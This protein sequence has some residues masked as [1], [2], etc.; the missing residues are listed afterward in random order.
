MPCISAM[1]LG[2]PTTTQAINYL[3]QWLAKTGRSE[4]SV[5]YYHNVCSKKSVLEKQ[6]LYLIQNRPVVS[7]SLF[8]TSGPF[9]I[10]TNP[11]FLICKS[12]SW[13]TLKSHLAAKLDPL[14][15]YSCQVFHCQILMF[16]YRVYSQTPLGYFIRYSR[17]TLLFLIYLLKYNSHVVKFTIFKFT[18]L[19]I[20]TNDVY[21][22]MATTSRYRTCPGP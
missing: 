7:Y 11:Q 13:K 9:W 21:S 12:K 19:W 2:T 22:C 5:F 14:N 8:Y 1:G 17:C 18:V 4:T 15:I 16:D 10:V 6:N 3:C 20:L